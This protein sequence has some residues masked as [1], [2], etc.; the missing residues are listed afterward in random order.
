[1]VA[2]GALDLH[3]AFDV[4]PLLTIAGARRP[5]QGR[6]TAAGRVS[7]ST[8]TGAL[9]LA[10]RSSC[11]RIAVVSS[12]NRRS[13]IV[14]GSIGHDRVVAGGVRL[15]GYTSSLAGAARRVG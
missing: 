15:K 3:C 13:A 12:G 8:K 6:D 11:H 2:N 7:V 5:P 14:G 10:Y 4:R 9:T 1:M